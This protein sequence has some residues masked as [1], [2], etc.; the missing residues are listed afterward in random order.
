MLVLFYIFNIEERT[1]A[2]LFLKAS[3]VVEASKGRVRAKL[4]VVE[5]D[6]VELVIVELDVVDYNRAY[7]EG[8]RES[9]IDVVISTVVISTVGISIVDMFSKEVI[10]L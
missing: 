10:V 8:I 1:L 3:R 4:D 7:K 5:L 6:I 2:T 9:I